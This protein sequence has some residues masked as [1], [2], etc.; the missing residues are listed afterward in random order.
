MAASRGPAAAAACK[1]S[2]PPPQPPR[3][4]CS[5]LRLRITAR[6]RPAG[7][8]VGAL[9]QYV[10]LLQISNSI[11]LWL[12]I[13]PPDLFFYAVRCACCAVCLCARPAAAPRMLLPGVPLSGTQEVPLCAA[14]ALALITPVPSDSCSSCRRCWWT[15]RF[16]PTSSCFQRWVRPSELLE[17]DCSAAGRRTR[18]ASRE[19]HA[20]GSARRPGTWRG[21]C[22]RAASPPR[23]LRL[24]LLLQLWV[25]AVLMAFV[26][27]TLSAIIL[28]PR[29]HLALA[30][31]PVQ[32]ARSGA[33]ACAVLHGGRVVPAPRCCGQAPLNHRLHLPS[34]PNPPN[35]SSSL[36][37]ALPTAASTGRTAPS[38]PP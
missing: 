19:Q 30:C 34:P 35:Q 18:G 16:A 6:P 10:N 32:P 13:S 29:E 5:P 24:L 27:V 7:G 3:L 14:S 1:P 33:G 17:T 22:R 9:N 28:T 12:S 20:S 36:C 23:L 15:A 2:S 11:T 21:P 26:M 4:E 31:L 25:H 38:L 37:W 8:C